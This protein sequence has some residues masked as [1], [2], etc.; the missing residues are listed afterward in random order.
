[1][2]GA[3]PRVIAT[4]HDYASLI[5]AFRAV[6]AQLQ[7]SNETVDALCGFTKGQCDKLLG[8]TC[9]RAFSPLTFN[10]LAWCLALKIEV[11]LDMNRVR[12]MQ[13]HWETRNGAQAR[14]LPSRISKVIVARA[15]P[16]VLS[17]LSKLGNEARQLMLPGKHR[18][19]IA[20]KAGRARWRKERELRRAARCQA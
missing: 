10:G 8:P 9:A 18:S 6:K 12:E 1:M 16:I 20:R 4:A 7:L 19:Q 15:K 17:D 2:S 3:K 11:S 14:A 13:A 5:E